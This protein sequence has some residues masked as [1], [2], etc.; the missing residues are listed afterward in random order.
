MPEWLKEILATFGP[1]NVVGESFTVFK[2]GDVDVSLP[3]RES[4]VGRGHKG[5]AVHGDPDAQAAIAP[6]INALGFETHIPKWHER[7]S[8]D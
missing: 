6:K 8:L 3:R 7:V 4:K 2:V 1:V 5:F